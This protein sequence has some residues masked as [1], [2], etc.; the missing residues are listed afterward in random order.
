MPLVLI[1]DKI[2][3]CAREIATRV[4][5]EMARL[6]EWTEARESVFM[7]AL[8]ESIPR[9]RVKLLRW[10]EQVLNQHPAI[11]MDKV[12]NQ[13][14][15]VQPSLNVVSEVQLTPEVAQLLQ[16]AAQEWTAD[17]ARKLFVDGA[18]FGVQ[19]TA[20]FVVPVGT[21][22]LV[23]KL[24]GLILSGA[25]KYIRVAGNYQPNEVCR[26]T[27]LFEAVLDILKQ[28]FSIADERLI[29]AGEALI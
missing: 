27:A 1:E 13:A 14:P 29:P 23:N 20:D 16:A 9:V 12:L 15:A 17:D 19:V 4:I 11:Q 7:A 25:L 5:A 6:N 21:T 2:E 26:I 24:F 3:E 10:C 8:R 18:S 22:P 28:R